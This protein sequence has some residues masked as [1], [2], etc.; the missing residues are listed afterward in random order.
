MGIFSDRCHALVDPGTGRALT[1]SALDEAKQKPDWPRCGK[2]VKKAAR[3]CS[4]CGKGAPGGWWKCPSCG[5]WVGNDS[6]FCWNCKTALYPES[7]DMI[8]GGVWQKP[9][10]LFAARFEVGDIKKLLKKGLQ[11]QTGTA[12]IL[13]DGGKFK[14]VI[15]PGNHN[16]DSLAHKINH[17]GSAPPRTVILVDNGDVGLPLRIEGLRS[18]E[19]MPLEFF[20]E[21]ILHFNPK[22]AEEF[23]TNFMKQE[24]QV[25]YEDLA[26]RMISEVRHAVEANCVRSSVDDLVKDPERR[27]RL[28]DELRDTLKQA[29]ERNGLELIRVASADFTGPEYEQLREKA[30][31]LEEKRRSLEF[32]TRMRELL[33]TD[34]MDELKTEHNLEEYVNQLAQE[35]E[36]SGEHRDHELE[37][38]RQA[39]RHEVDKNDVAYKMAR[40][41]EQA[42]HEIDVKIEW[43]IYTREKLQKDAE[44]QAAVKE[45]EV[46]S[47][48]AEAGKWIDVRKRKLEVNREDQQARLE[49]MEGKDI[50]TL[51]AAVDDPAKRQELLELNQQLQQA[52]QTPEQI[53]A[54]AAASSP[55]AARALQELAGQRNA[56]KDA[57]IEERQ[58]IYEQNADRLERVLKTALEASK[59]GGGKGG[60]DVHIL[61]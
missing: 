16:L 45:V 28:E 27:L 60:G 6:N 17:W 50:Q 24:S 20:G 54:S 37:L 35:K 3:F 22:K 47:E 1:G 41:M 25:A 39:H 36:V 44:I 46:D 51:I 55:E 4:K 7:R 49:M 2:K 43:D 48:V 34:R 12:A 32:D 14:D 57:E 5:K 61:K 52:G 31:K 19:E 26:D 33:T 10:E 13:L 42:A 23:I 53:L 59:H 11:V 30:G 18:A 8:A 58:K 15:G 29:L 9:A 56:D 38:L 21:M 40:E